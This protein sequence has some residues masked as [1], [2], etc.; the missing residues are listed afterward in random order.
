MKHR[1][2]NKSLEKCHLE[3]V[4]VIAMNMNWAVGS[5]TTNEGS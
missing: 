3:N 4:M 2:T 5:T 1:K